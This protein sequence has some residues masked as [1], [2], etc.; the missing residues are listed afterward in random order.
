MGRKRKRTQNFAKPKQATNRSASSHTMQ[1]VVSP[2][3][4]V[5][6]G[7]IPKAIDALRTQLINEPTD[8]RKRLLG[9]C[10]FQIGDYKEAANAWLTLNAPTANDLANAGAAWLNED[11][12][13][14]ARSALQRSLD[15][16]EHAYPLYLQALAIK[17]DREYYTLRGEDYAS[18]TDLLQKAQTLPNCPANAL[19]LLDD[20]LN[21]LSFVQTN[22][23]VHGS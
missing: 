20:L 19:L 11:E 12:W 2:E 15:L 18:V 23:N 13:E 16:E 17:G 1:L 21:Y 8:E 7:D 4:L 6:N 22:G 9:D 14:R 5:K 10:Y 3:Q